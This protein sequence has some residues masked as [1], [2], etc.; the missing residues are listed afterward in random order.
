[1]T[2]PAIWSI[3]S[4][5]SCE[6]SKNS[7]G[8]NGRGKPGGDPSSSPPSPFDPVSLSGMDNPLNVYDDSDSLV[9]LP[10][11]ATL[12]AMPGNSDA[13]TRVEGVKTRE[14]DEHD[15]VNGTRNHRTAHGERAAACAPPTD[16]GAA[17]I[18]NVLNSP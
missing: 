6:L 15:A 7:D 16:C 18:F 11:A 4:S 12:P 10:A 3:A 17:I 1:M 8:S 2:I 9:V 13:A 14:V 5:K